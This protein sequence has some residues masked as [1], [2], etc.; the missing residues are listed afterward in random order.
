MNLTSMD[1]DLI[2]LKSEFTNLIGVE[3]KFVKN[4]KK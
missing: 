3:V 4:L 1:M 2:M